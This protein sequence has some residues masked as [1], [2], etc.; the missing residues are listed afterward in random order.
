MTAV[1]RADQTAAL[2]RE[3]A[4]ERG[5]TITADDR[6]FECDL[7]ELLKLNPRHLADLRTSGTPLCP[8]YRAVGNKVSYRI[9]EVAAAIESTR[10]E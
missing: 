4:R 2:L 7:T 8:Y 10:Y 6:I 3:S 1:D 9:S 5:F